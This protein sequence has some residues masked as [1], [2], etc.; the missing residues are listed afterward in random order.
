MIAQEPQNRFVETERI[1]DAALEIIARVGL[2][3]L[4]LRDLAQSIGKSTTVIVNLFG[5]KA[6]LIE[7]V[8][9]V[10]LA[11]D[12]AFHRDFFA[13][14]DH[15]PPGRDALIGVILSYLK[16]RSSSQAHGARVIEALILTHDP[17]EARRDF[18]LRWDQIR[19]RA[20][21]E[22]LER[23]AG[24]HGVSGDFTPF[25]GGFLLME[26]YYAVALSD[27][28]DYGAILVETVGAMV[29]RAMDHP[30]GPAV[31]TDWFTHRLIIPH[32]PAEGLDPD[33]MKL[34]LLNIAAD[35]ILGQ[36]VNGVTNR[37]V[38]LEAGT[39]TSTIAHH[40]G[41][42]GQFL[43]DAVW[44][45][46]FREMPP[47]LD[48]R[49]LGRTGPPTDVAGWA[50]LIAPTL[51]PADGFYVKYARLIAQICL[52]ARLE[53]GFQDLAMIL[54][55]P[56]GGGTYT[57]RADVWPETFDL[58]RLA[59]SRFAIWIKGQALIVSATQQPYGVQQLQDA[60]RALVHTR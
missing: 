9:E 55:G 20:W 44:H 7:A 28:S 33:S 30:D 18:I 10:A 4:T 21:R 6:G 49:R 56:E 51:A 57:N 48:H 22:F 2:D 58:T 15:L 43:M 38:S 59:A 36:G 8:S 29:D 54:R 50:E 40:W 60:A 1:L 24:R 45:S 11:Q 27:R 16:V 52:K 42:M 35:Q 37:S 31:A 17:S 34:R 13:R 32:E 46:V 26:Q 41:D 12:E 39:S 19:L 47:Y 25:L 3:G 14:L 5:S 53:P 23:F